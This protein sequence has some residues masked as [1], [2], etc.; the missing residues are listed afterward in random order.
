MPLS[1]N[2]IRLR[3]FE[4]PLMNPKPPRP[5]NSNKEPAAEQD[6]SRMSYSQKKHKTVEEFES[7]PA[8]QQF[9][10]EMREILADMSDRVEKHFPS[11]VVEDMQ[12]ALRL[13]E[14]R[15]LN[16]K[17]CYFSDDRVAFYT[18]GKR[19]FDLLQRLLKNDS[20][21][22]DLRVS[23]IKNVISELGACGAGMLPKIGDE[24]N[25]L[26]N[27]NG[28]LLAISWQCKHDIIEQQIH[29]Y[30]RK[31]RSYR[32]ANEIHEYRAFANYAADRLGLESR[33]D[34]FAPR[35]I[36]FEELEECTTEVEDSMCPGYLALHLAERYREAFID[37]LSK[38]TH[39][40]REQLTRGIAYD[41][42][43][44]LTADRI[45]DELAPTY[46]A[47][48]I[49]HRSAGILAFDDDSGIIHVPAEL[50]L[51]ARDILRAQATA[52]YV[53][54]QYKE[55][56]LLIGWKEPG[57]GLQVQ[58]RYNDEILVW[59]TAGG[60]AVPLT[61]E[62]LMQVPR[63]N[64]DDLVRD[65]PELVA[66]LARTVINCEPDDRLLMLPPQWLNTNNSCR[67]FLARLD[68]QQAR[69]YLQAHSEKLGKHAKEG[70][71]AAVFDE[72]RLALLDFMVGSL[73]VSSKSTQKMLETWFSDSLKLGLKAEVRAIEPYLLDVI[74]RNVLNAK[75]EEKYIS[76]KHTCANVIN[77]AVRIKHDDFV[78][79]YLDLISTPAVMA[80][81]TRKEIVELLELEGLPKAL[82][83][84]RASLIK[85]YI[86]TLT[87]A[88]IDK[89]I[90]SDDYCGLIGSILSESYIS[91]V[92]PGFSPGAF[93]AYLNGIAIACRQGVIDKKQYFSLLKADSESGLRLSAMKS[94]IFSSANKSF[95]ALYFDKL[96]EAFINKLI[97]ANEFFESISG[98]LMDPGVGLEEFRIH[99]NSFEMYF[100]RVREAHAN[101]YV[102]QLRF[103]EIM[104]SSL[105][106]A[107]S[108]QLLTAA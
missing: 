15:L 40:T 33:E 46:G 44:L 31:H 63:Q 58:I 79:A 97:D 96:E 98:A 86:R 75:A 61:V 11:E 13:F 4:Q 30:I 51:L 26:C 60:K 17:I 100:R 102:N 70:F 47:D 80:G 22:L 59:A 85:T 101:G 34:R 20:I 23:V 50:T 5:V 36:S 42:A 18:E 9:K 53:E 62:H 74:E 78:V 38:E 77:G 87:K 93:R 52:G 68:D 89:K 81:L 16:L 104:S 67:S 99:R 83:Q 57:T 82:S 29:D 43:I 28:G 41:E 92:G 94:L 105:G 10:E 2:H 12:Y 6:A 90:G 84:D 49:Q 73:S 66:L 107:Y 19:N 72:K 91:R 76:L 56:E 25:R 7:S 95:I 21:P 37:R 71:A 88:A 3:G 103:D 64:L 35:D 24:I 69:T 45:V 8:F 48:T 65:R 14:R 55:G 106:L 27:G 54:P 1:I 32:P 108:R 39:L